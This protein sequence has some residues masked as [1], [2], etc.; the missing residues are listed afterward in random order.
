MAEDFTPP[1]GR[2]GPR[3]RELIRFILDCTGR[4]I[5][6]CSAAVVAFV[7]IFIF[8]H[9]YGYVVLRVAADAWNKAMDVRKAK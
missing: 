1:P 4:F 2:R 8:V 6:N 7:L 5:G 3:Q 9:V